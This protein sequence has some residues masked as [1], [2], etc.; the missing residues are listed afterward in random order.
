MTFAQGENMPDNDI[1]LVNSILEVRASGLE[2]AVASD[3]NQPD[4]KSIAELIDDQ[5]KENNK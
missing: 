4:G 2:K 3:L 5:E 1:N